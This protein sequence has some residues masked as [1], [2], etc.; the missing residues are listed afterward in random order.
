MALMVYDSDPNVAKTCF[1][2]VKSGGQTVF[3]DSPL[4]KVVYAQGDK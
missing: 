1:V 2:H 4:E 3:F